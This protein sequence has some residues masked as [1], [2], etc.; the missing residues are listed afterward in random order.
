MDPQESG[1]QV[2]QKQASKLAKK[3]LRKNLPAPPKHSKKGAK[4]KKFAGP[5]TKIKGY[6]GY[7]GVA[8][9]MAHND[10]VTEH[11]AGKVLAAFRLLALDSRSYTVLEKMHMRGELSSTR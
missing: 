8:T 11:A 9:I 6:S 4:E 1:D 10:G 2:N 3:M 5:R 7:A